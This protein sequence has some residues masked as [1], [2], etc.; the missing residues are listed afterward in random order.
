MK[1]QEALTIEYPGFSNKIIVKI[2]VT[3]DKGENKEFP[4]LID[5]GAT[6]TC[7]SSELITELELVSIGQI[8]TGT[9]NGKTEVDI[10]VVDLSLCDGR[11]VFPKHKVISANLTEQPGVE[12]LIGMDVLSC[13]DFAIT[14]K[15]GKTMAS[16][17]IPSMI[18]IDFVPNANNSN[19]IE[20]ERSKRIANKVKG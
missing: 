11:V 13:G 15:D 7:V 12:M 16:F 18:S 19:K 20:L 5:T 14:H 2:L 3:N 17:R 9:A 1:R 4:G 10:Y 6:N 8:E